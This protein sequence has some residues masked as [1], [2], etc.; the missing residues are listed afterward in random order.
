MR[1]NLAALLCLPVICMPMAAQN[2]TP[3]EAEALVKEAI[4]YAKTHGKD[5]A[6]K[7]ITR[8]DGS[9]RKHGG[10]LY[11]FVNTMDGKNLAH[12]MGARFVGADQSKAKDPDGVEYMQE[13]IKLAKTKGK[14]WH[15]YK[16]LNPKTGKK[17]TKASYIEVWDG[18]IFGAGIYKK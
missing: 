4:A 12:G 6:C 8:P 13:R 11:V 16:Y 7:E 15:E 10:E 18:L 17:E 2:A 9:L 14:G 5:A 3:A 1:P